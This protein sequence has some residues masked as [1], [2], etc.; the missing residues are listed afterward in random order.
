MTIPIM[1]ELWTTLNPPIVELMGWTLLH[2]VWQ[3]A[4]VAALLGGLLRLLDTSVPPVRYAVCCVALIGLLAFPIGTGLFLE[5]QLLEEESASASQVVT[6][7][8][9]IGA[10]EGGR[11]ALAVSSSPASPSWRAQAASW[12]RPVLPWLV[13]G[14]GLGVLGFSMRLAGGAW[15]V[16]RLRR[17]GTPA[18]DEWR[19]RLRA[20]A[21]SLGLQGPVRLCRSP[22]VDSPM[23]LG[24][25]R[26]VVLV[27]AGFLAGMPPAQVEALLLHELA[28]VRRHDVLV[29]RL[30]AVV[31]VLLFFHPATWWISRQVRREREACCDD[32]VVRAGTDRT[33]YARA[34]ATLAER[35]QV[36]SPRAW[37]PA[38]SDGSLL[39]RIRRLANP[40]SVPSSGL[41][42]LSI[43]AAVLLLVGVPVGLAACASQQSATEAGAED[44]SSPVVRSDSPTEPPG[45]T[46]DT[47]KGKKHPWFVTP[48]DSTRFSG[49]FLFRTP[50]K[51][52]HFEGDLFFHHDETRTDTLSFFRH[53]GEHIDTLEVPSLDFLSDLDSLRQHLDGH[54]D[55]D[56][57]GRTIFRR[58][59]PDS[60]E[61]AF[62]RK[63]NPDTLER[64]LRFRLHPDSL[65]QVIQGAIPR[66]SLER[67]IRAPFEGTPPERP[68]YP[69]DSLRHHLDSLRHHA[70]QRADSLR[71]QAEQRADSLRHRAEQRADSLRRHLDRLREQRE[72]QMSEQ[73]REEARRLRE[74]AERLEERARELEEQSPPDSEETS[75]D[76]AFA[77]RPFEGA[78]PVDT[79]RGRRL[80]VTVEGH[81]VI[82]RS[83]AHRP[84]YIEEQAPVYAA[85]VVPPKSDFDIGT[86]GVGDRLSGLLSSLE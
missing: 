16:R 28:H 25:W 54:V 75:L 63:I 39:T 57:L 81:E 31:E 52:D 51:D 44:P 70:Q 46:T 3:G 77:A 68:R 32:L 86:A 13:L 12:V 55:L 22:S 34:L 48:E 26:P 50:K 27:P 30:Q 35:V 53:D 65:E 67:M 49:S 4:L 85:R 58:V 20:L 78:Q 19:E 82:L 45:A 33:V 83:E 11:E 14:W 41:Q 8:V 36:G 47:A 18:P 62:F 21:D 59:N 74:Q 76:S 84:I 64:A 15:R 6:E 80:E 73:L 5:G 40:A 2:F 69:S 60:L 29:G 37:V 71:R 7:A 24:W 9:P 66:D 38:A 61:K 42:R 79:Y 43:A 1:P 56:S 23:L 17:S 72:Q 10:G